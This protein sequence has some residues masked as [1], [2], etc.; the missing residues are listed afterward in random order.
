MDFIF[1]NFGK[2]WLLILGLNIAL[3]IF[4]IWVIVKLMQHFGVI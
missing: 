4:G 2:L 3:I 1:N